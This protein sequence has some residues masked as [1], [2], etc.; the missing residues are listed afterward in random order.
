VVL[1]RQNRWLRARFGGRKSAAAAVLTVIVVLAVVVPAIVVGYAFFDEAVSLGHDLSALASRFRITGYEDLLK[2][3]LLGRGFAWAEEHFG[4]DAVKLQSGLIEAIRGVVAWVAGHGGQALAGAFS[5]I[6]GV[7]LMLFLLF[8]FFRD[9]DE[10]AARLLDLV[11][12]EPLRK[13]RLIEHLTSVT[14]AVVKGTLLTAVAQGVLVAVGFAIVGLPSPVV[15]GALTAIA[16]F[17]PLVGTGLVLAP[18][19]L[20]LATL[21]VWWKTIFLLVWGVV[22]AGSADNF[23][24]PMLISGRAEI[25]TLTAFVGAVGGIATFGLVGLFLGPVIMSLAVALVRFAEESR[26]PGT[27]PPG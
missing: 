8:F 25:G 3:P 9:G 7:V 26:R 18:A 11:P 12:I 16:S 24:R 19:V 1:I 20:Y 10:E 5:L 23:L 21:G 4:L 13:R 27:A 14:N 22:V 6:A 2:I 17:V 15:F